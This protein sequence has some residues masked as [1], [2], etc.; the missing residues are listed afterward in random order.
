[1]IAE[2][3][4]Q[5]LPKNCL[6]TTELFQHL[7][8]IPEPAFTTQNDARS[9]FPGR[10]KQMYA[11]CLFR[12]CPWCWPLRGKKRRIG[13]CLMSNRLSVFTRSPCFLFGKLLSSPSSETS[14]KGFSKYAMLA[15]IKDELRAP[16]RKRYSKRH[17]PQALDYFLREPS[18]ELLIHET[19][20]FRISAGFAG[21]H[22]HQI[23][24]SLCSPLKPWSFPKGSAQQ[25]S[26]SVKRLAR[27]CLFLI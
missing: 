3:R 27:L 18:F 20:C 21:R 2:Q 11:P 8:H 4:G 15:A 7:V 13:Y 24:E 22:V 6:Y 26:L 14:R 10:L 9:P 5:E 1:M 16:T 25:L 17:L 23:I 19:Q 12:S